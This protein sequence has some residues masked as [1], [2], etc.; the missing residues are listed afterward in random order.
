MFWK[1]QETSESTSF[2][3]SEFSGT[4]SGKDIHKGI[5]KPDFKTFSEGAYLIVVLYNYQ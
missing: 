1:L 2:R 5:C 4:F 3:P